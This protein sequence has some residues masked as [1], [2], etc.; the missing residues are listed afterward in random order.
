M[1]LYSLKKC[2]M[3]QY[4]VRLMGIQRQER[5]QKPVMTLSCRRR[6]HLLLGFG[7]EGIDHLYTLLQSL[8]LRRRSEGGR[9]G[10]VCCGRT[11]LVLAQ[12]DTLLSGLEVAVVTPELTHVDVNGT[13]DMCQLRHP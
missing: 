6:V 2:T 10:G 1:I 12:H 11:Y 5:Q 4:M 7:N 3:L 8:P 13:Y 9:F